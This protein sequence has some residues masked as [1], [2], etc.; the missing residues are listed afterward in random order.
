MSTS[1]ELFPLREMMNVDAYEGGT[2]NLV[3]SQEWPSLRGETYS[4]IMLPMA[5]AEALAFAIL[6][7]ARGRQ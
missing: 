7:I 1:A 5:E 4:R 6:A 2:G 3:L